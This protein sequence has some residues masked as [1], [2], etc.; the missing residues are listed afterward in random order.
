MTPSNPE[1]TILPFLTERIAHTQEG[2]VLESTQAD[3]G[4][5]IHVAFFPTRRHFSLMLPRTQVNGLMF[6]I[7]RLTSLFALV[8]FFASLFLDNGDP[9]SKPVGAFF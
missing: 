4:P 5:P 8:V 1:V 3:P 7:F 9:D 2:E 6:S